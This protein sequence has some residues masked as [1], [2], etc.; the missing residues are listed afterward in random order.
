MTIFISVKFVRDVIVKQLDTGKTFT[1]LSLSFQENTKLGFY[2]QENQFNKI[3]TILH[4]ED[5]FIFFGSSPMKLLQTVYRNFSL[6]KTT[7][8]LT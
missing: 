3:R 5:T 4:T 1:S 2:S 7:A 6:R 8:L